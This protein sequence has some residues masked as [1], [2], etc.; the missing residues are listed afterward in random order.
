[1][2]SDVIDILLAKFGQQ[3]HEYDI[4][5]DRVREMGK[6]IGIQMCLQGP[7]VTKK[8]KAPDAGKGSDQQSVF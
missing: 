4:G 8:K 3:R 2:L 5:D 6:D 7:N 1:M